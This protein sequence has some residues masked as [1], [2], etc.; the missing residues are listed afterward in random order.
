[1][2]STTKS[3]KKTSKKASAATTE[4]PSLLTLSGC[5]FQNQPEPV[6][7]VRLRAE[8]IKAASE[9][10]GKIADALKGNMQNAPLLQI[11]QPKS[12]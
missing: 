6:E 5:N 7:S 8:A 2:A 11:N 4:K 12:D 10:L 9:A 3:K 1:M